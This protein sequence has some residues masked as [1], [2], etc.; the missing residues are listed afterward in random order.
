M[1]W[2]SMLSVM[3]CS[4]KINVIN[5][6]LHALG[7]DQLTKGNADA[8]RTQWPFTESFLKRCLAFR[9]LMTIILLFYNLWWKFPL[10]QT[11][12]WNRFMA[13]IICYSLYLWPKALWRGHINYYLRAKVGCVWNRVMLYQINNFWNFPASIFILSIIFKHA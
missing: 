1:M 7:N 12:F 8:Q 11:T 13:L 4:V 6:G 2:S 5:N 9:T 3:Y 10:T